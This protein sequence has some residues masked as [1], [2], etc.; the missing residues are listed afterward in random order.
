MKYTLVMRW[1][2][3]Q[4]WNKLDRLEEGLDFQVNNDYKKS[5]EEYLKSIT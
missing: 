4:G 3:N 5:A 2:G 1:N